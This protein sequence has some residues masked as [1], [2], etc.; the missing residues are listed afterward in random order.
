MFFCM[1]TENDHYQPHS[2]Y[3]TLQA[4]IINVTFTVF[5]T[6]A[7][8]LVRLCL[9]LRLCVTAAVLKALPVCP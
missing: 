8:K 4:K 9:R 1:K 5:F 7:I 2:L 6:S 3:T